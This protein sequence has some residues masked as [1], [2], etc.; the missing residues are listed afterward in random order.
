[1]KEY[2]G[3]GGIAPLSNLALDGRRVFSFKPGERAAA[4]GTH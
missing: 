3:R 1:M 4:A 2:G